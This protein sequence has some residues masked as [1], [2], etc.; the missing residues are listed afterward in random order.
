MG[1]S[2]LQQQARRV[3]QLAHALSC[4]NQRTAASCSSAAARNPGS[5]S[6]LPSCADAS[7][8]H[9]HAQLKKKEKERKAAGKVGAPVSAEAKKKSAADACAFLCGVCRQ[10][11][12]VNVRVSPSR[13]ATPAVRSFLRSSG[14][15]AGR[16]R[17][18]AA[19]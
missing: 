7:L 17:S 16:A 18:V 15:D 9:F 4:R 2:K 11:F 19:R 12:P 6:A 10:A 13:S 5:D 1:L 14:G 3:A 8:P